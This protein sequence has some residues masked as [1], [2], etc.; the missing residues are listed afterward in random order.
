MNGYWECKDTGPRS[1]KKFGRRVYQG[2]KG[3]SCKAL[4]TTPV[5]P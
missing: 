5:E 1:G 3:T 4:R 2:K